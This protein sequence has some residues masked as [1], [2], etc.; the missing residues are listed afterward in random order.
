M[1]TRGFADGI[2]H[3]ALVG[4]AILNMLTVN[5]Q[6]QGGSE[7]GSNRWRTGRLKALPI[8]HTVDKNRG[9][10]YRDFTGLDQVNK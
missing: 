5:C 3:L 4:N 9:T 2:R 1:G 6:D 10:P 8:S 7:I